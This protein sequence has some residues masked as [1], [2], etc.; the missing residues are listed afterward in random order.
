MATYQAR[1]IRQTEIA[2]DTGLFEFTKPRGFAF[3]AG[4]AV[5]V[6]LPRFDP[7]AGGSNLWEG[8]MSQT[9]SLVSAPDESTLSI[10]TRER[11][12]LFKKKLFALKTGDK[13]KIEGPF[14]SFCL[15]TDESRP[16]C[17]RRQ[18]IFIAGGIGITPFISMLREI[19]PR[20]D[21]ESGKRSNLGEIF[22]F[23]SN[24]T[25][26]D[27][28]FLEELRKYAA[29]HENF[30]FVPTFTAS[31]PRINKKMLKKY[32]SILPTVS[33]GCKIENP[34]RS[35]A[36]G[37]QC[38]KP[39]FYIAGTLGFVV[40]MREEVLALDVEDNDIKTDEFLGY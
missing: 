26:K 29:R 4:Q 9:F 40:A 10:A 15:H 28:A 22:L 2:R 39:V 1:L 30:I 37:K 13:I 33:C 21:L 27:A 6:I 11:E 31:S 35:A 16:A 8:K 3:R 18:A 7:P 17:L 36:R 38:N 32:L 25:E 14:G 5:D 19:S 12:S 24:R 20:F 23:Y 34:A